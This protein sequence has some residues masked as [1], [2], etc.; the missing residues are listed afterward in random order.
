MNC[1]NTHRIL[2]LLIYPCSD[3][4]AIQHIRIGTIIHLIVVVFMMYDEWLHNPSVGKSVKPEFCEYFQN[5]LGFGFYG[6]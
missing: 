2:I 5:W 6:V 4:G 3:Y 1:E